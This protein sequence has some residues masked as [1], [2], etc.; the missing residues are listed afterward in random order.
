MA[1]KQQAAH[2]VKNYLLVLLLSSGHVLA[3]VMMLHSSK[4][5]AHIIAQHLGVALFAHL[6]T[7]NT[8]SIRKRENMT[9]EEIKL[10]RE[11]LNLSQRAAAKAHDV[12]LSTYQQWERGASWTTGKPRRIKSSVVAMCE[13]ISHYHNKTT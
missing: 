6:A 7:G 2:V 12:T 11:S 8:N 5:Y 3:L 4:K 10:W 1:V 13:K 9:H